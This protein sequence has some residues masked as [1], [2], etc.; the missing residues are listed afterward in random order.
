M[1]KVFFKDSYF[2]LTDKENLSKQATHYLEHRDIKTTQQFIYQRLKEDAKFIS[3]IYG[4]NLQEVVSAFNTCF[5]Q[6][7]A[8]GGVVYK[9]EKILIIKRF[10]MYDLPKGHLEKNENIEQ[11][12][13]REVEEECG[14]K[15][16]KITRYLTNTLHIYFRDNT[17]QLKETYWYL[18]ISTQDFTL[19]PQQEE[20]IEEVIWYPLSELNSILQKS[21]PSLIPVF[22]AIKKLHK[23]D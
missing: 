19:I 4:N 7:K 15:A 18:M 5:Q 11:C 12:A 20:G 13:I 16:L 23:E 3:I 14:A 1:Y 22:Q 21:Y 8:A 9:Q 2:L 17:W 10:G 6:V